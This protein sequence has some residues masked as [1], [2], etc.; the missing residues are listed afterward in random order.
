MLNNKSHLEAAAG[1]SRS[2]WCELNLYDDITCISNG[3]E[4]SAL[5]TSFKRSEQF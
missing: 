3:V 5:N 1:A 2:D 4:T